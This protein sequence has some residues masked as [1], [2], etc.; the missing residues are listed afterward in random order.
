MAS[1]DIILSAGKGYKFAWEERAYLARLAL[2]PLIFKLV[3]SVA[4]LQLGWDMHFF[5]K[6]LLLL[7]AYFAEG[8]MLSHVARTVL[9]G[10]RWPFQP[11]GNPEIDLPALQDRALGIM[12]GT[13]VYVLTEFLLMGA[14]G[15][16]FQ[17]AYFSAQSI[18]S[19]SAGPE[20]TVLSGADIETVQTGVAF[21][22][23][24]IL[25]MTV[26]VFRYL[27]LYIPAAVNVPLRDFIRKLNGLSTSF[28]ALGLWLVCFLPPVFAV[29]LILSVLMAGQ[30]PPS[31]SSFI[32]LLLLVVAE[33][34]S[35]IVMTAAVAHGFQQMMRGGPSQPPSL[36]SSRGR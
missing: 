10:H 32:A 14:G 6:A 8:W 36:P 26:W 31:V 16:L 17:T 24:F 25:F 33:T 15:F 5:R 20:A 9:L 34:V 35:A 18:Q 23:L 13:L 11:T 29:R 3:L 19:G 27:W 7:P 12:R 30:F 2:I 28:L 22:T 4:A 1:F 21:L